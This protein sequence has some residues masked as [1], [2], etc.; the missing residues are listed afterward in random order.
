[1]DAKARIGAILVSLGMLL[2]APSA[3]AKPMSIFEVT[4]LLSHGLAENE[5]HL[6]YGIGEGEVTRNDPATFVWTLT[7]KPQHPMP[8]WRAPQIV[9][10]LDEIAPCRVRLN[11]QTYLPTSEGPKSEH[12]YD[13][14]LLTDVT[15]ERFTTG[16][17]AEAAEALKL[18]AFRVKFKP[19]AVAPAS[20]QQVASHFFTSMDVSDVQRAADR[21]R[22]L[23]Q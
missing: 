4:A 16:R 12:I 21:L 17:T 1:M 13:F 6:I 23:C 22:E 2:V 14:S 5:R 3:G 7:T 18:N 15:V 19:D 8:N 20:Y 11:I 9:F 10:A